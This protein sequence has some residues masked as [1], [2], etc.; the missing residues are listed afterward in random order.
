MRYFRFFLFICIFIMITDIKGVE[1]QSPA[2]NLNPYTGWGIL[3]YSKAPQ[4]CEC[5]ISSPCPGGGTVSCQVSGWKYCFCGPTYC[6]ITLPDS[7]S[8]QV[9]GVI[10][11]SDVSY[12]PPVCCPP[13]VPPKSLDINMP[14]VESYP[15]SYV[16]KYEHR[17]YGD[18]LFWVK[19][20]LF[21]NQLA[22]CDNKLFYYRAQGHTLY[23]SVGDSLQLNSI[24][25][26]IKVAPLSCD[27]LMIVSPTQFYRYT[28][29][30]HS[31]EKLGEYNDGSHLPQCVEIKLPYIVISTLNGVKVFLCEGDNMQLMAQFQPELP[32]HNIKYSWQR[33]ILYR[34]IIGEESIVLVHL[35]SPYVTVYS[36]KG[37]H[38]RSM[39]FSYPD[40][41]DQ[42]TY[43]DT[44]L[45]IRSTC[46]ACH[47]IKCFLFDASLVENDKLL[48]GFCGAW[49]I[50][51][52]EAM[53]VRELAFY[54][55]QN[56]GT[57]IS[58]IVPNA[59]GEIW[60]WN[61]VPLIPENPQIELLAF[62]K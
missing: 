46:E 16:G 18:T 44:T 60:L 62:K 2:T 3:A 35:S 6:K 13:P 37:E 5:E 10:C 20:F 17:L 61:I 15:V 53:E 31:M 26:I 42:L 40:Y 58:Q 8:V 29:S 45:K 47:K 9:P 1:P 28:I 39:Y 32:S 52:L 36:L 33:H 48:C 19:P 49:F 22:W 11:F 57:F 27:E 43:V 56:N 38:K 55:R 21:F 51:D 4:G 23:T 24:D 59:D 54:D 30:T 12:S 34:P 25:G 7:N 50:I 41:I 14:D